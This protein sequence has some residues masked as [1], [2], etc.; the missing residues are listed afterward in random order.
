MSRYDQGEYDR[1]TEHTSEPFEAP[2]PPTTIG[3][4]VAVSRS[5][6][7]DSG[8]IGLLAVVLAVFMMTAIWYRIRGIEDRQSEII[9]KIMA[10]QVSM[11]AF[12][13]QHN[14][15]E[16][17]RSILMQSQIKLLRLLCQNSAKS[18]FQSAKCS[19]E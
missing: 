15:I 8:T 2:I 12:A 19:T 4:A 3:G 9:G 5:I 1:L 11:G 7:Q 14:E 10:S 18:E 16:S 17:Q 13:A 6:L